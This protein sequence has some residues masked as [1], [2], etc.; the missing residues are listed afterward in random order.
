VAKIGIWAPSSP[1]A[2][3]DF[4]SGL[5]QLRRLGLK[6]EVPELVARN[7]FKK[8]SAD[9]PFLAG[10]DSDKITSLLQLWKNSNVEKIMAVR[11]GA[12]SLRL[13]SALEGYSSV[14]KKSAKEIWGFSDLTTLQNYFYFRYGYS[15]V[16]SPMLTSPVL[17]S[18]NPKE[19]KY[20]RSVLDTE[21]PKV[22]D[23]FRLKA[24]FRPK[25]KKS[26][27]QGDVFGG[28]LH[29]LVNLTGGPW[30]LRQK[31][32]NILFLED[33]NEAPYRLD[34]LLTQ[35][36]HA[37]FSA[38]IRAVVLGHFTNCQ[39]YRPII[40]DWAQRN[41]L[42]LFAGFPAGHD[43]PNLPFSMGVRARLESTSQNSAILELPRPTLG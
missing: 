38:D 43:R 34:R 7:A 33:L 4:Y 14:F 2:R 37:N 19:K 9:H 28:N 12:G 25:N 21:G 22:W 16:H 24:L 31:T 5:R 29:C 6:T 18:P 1:A 26:L 30:D 10:Q 27:I 39:N 41:D 20:W 36:R 13:I 40:L 17:L 35:L 23:K 11:G 32:G 42:P 3:K 15:W 8:L